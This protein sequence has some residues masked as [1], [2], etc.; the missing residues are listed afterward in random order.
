MHHEVMYQ[1]AIYRVRYSGETQYWRWLSNVEAKL[2]LRE[3]AI[4]VVLDCFL[5]KYA[6]E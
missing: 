2:R 1:W 5:A 6:K 3:A 4:C